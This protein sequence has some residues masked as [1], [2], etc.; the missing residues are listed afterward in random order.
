MK[1]KQRLKKAFPK[2]TEAEIEKMAD[3]AFAEHKGKIEETLSL[4]NLH[5]AGEDS[6]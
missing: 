6:V 1:L 5:A 2:K 4:D 3:A